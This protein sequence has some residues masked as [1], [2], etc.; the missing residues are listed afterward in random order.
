MK[1][2]TIQ[3]D[4]KQ[5]IVNKF[6]QSYK[7][8]LSAVDADEKKKTEVLNDYLLYSFGY[9]KAPSYQNLLIESE[10]KKY[11]WIR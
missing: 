7:I 10:L 11:K 4:N 5:N 3:I 2:G 1:S 9:S 8:M 6:Y